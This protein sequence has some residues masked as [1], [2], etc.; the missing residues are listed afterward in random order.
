MI[1]K[2]NFWKRNFSIFNFIFKLFYV[3]RTR[4]KFCNDGAIRDC[5]FAELVLELINWY[6]CARK[7]RI[8][9]VIKQMRT[10]KQMQCSR[11]VC[12]FIIIYFVEYKH[13]CKCRVNLIIREGLRLNSSVFVTWC[14]FKIY[15]REYVA[16]FGLKFTRNQIWNLWLFD[17]HL[18]WHLHLFD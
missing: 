11:R 18:I 10:P 16:W 6:C 15:T 14:R 12:V 1:Q 13:H 4:N 2:G 7:R 3:V 5:A 9:T 8:K 17:M